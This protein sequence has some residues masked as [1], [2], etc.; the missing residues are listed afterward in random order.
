MI[1]LAALPWSLLL[2]SKPV[3]GSPGL[4]QEGLALQSTWELSPLLDDG[5]ARW[6][7]A[8]A[9]G[10]EL[11]S[12]SGTLL[13]S[14]TPSPLQRESLG[15]IRLDIQREE[16]SQDSEDWSPIAC[17]SRGG[18]PFSLHLE[19]PWESLEIPK[20]WGDSGQHC[21][22]HHLAT[23]IDLPFAENKNKNRLT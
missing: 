6:S 19:I 23:L 7:Q 2:M 22:L 13:P 4:G 14:S 20:D 8:A 16:R 1:G 5:L 10:C 9:G 11:T 21:V 17:P 3:P 18:R 12:C 15:T